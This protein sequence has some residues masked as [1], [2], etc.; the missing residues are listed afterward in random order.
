MVDPT[1][2]TLDRADGDADPAAGSATG[3]G[4]SQM[5]VRGKV[6]HLQV[7]GTETNSYVRI[8]MSGDKSDVPL[9]GPRVLLESL[10]SDAPPKKLTTSAAD[11]APAFWLDDTEVLFSR[12]TDEGPQIMSVPVGGGE[13]RVVGAGGL[14]A[15]PIPGSRDFVYIVPGREGLPFEIVSYGADGEPGGE[16]DAADISTADL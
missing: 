3:I 6:V 14:Q 10:D 11:F 13:P 2:V 9:T 15:D 1:P 12:Q 16:G 5:Q 8:D 4:V 7:D